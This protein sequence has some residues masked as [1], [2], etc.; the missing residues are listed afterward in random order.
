MMSRRLYMTTLWAWLTLV[1]AFGQ[2]LRVT[3]MPQQPISVALG[4]YSG[5]TWIFGNRYAVVDDKLPGGGIVFFDIPIRSDGKVRESQVQMTVPDATLSASVAGLDNEGVVF[6]HGKLYVSAE[7]DQSIREYDLDGRATGVVFSIPADLGAKA[8]VK[9]GGFEA[10]TW[11][12]ATGQFWTTT[13]LPLKADGKA[14][15]LHRLQRFDERYLANGRWLYRMDEPVLSEKER[16]SVMAYVHGISAMTALDDGRL[17]I[18]EREVYVPAGKPRDILARSFTKTKLYVVNPSGDPA[19]IL[20]KQLLCD[21]ETRLVMTAAGIDVALANYEGMCLGPRLPDGR[22]CLVLIAD[23]Q[24]GMATLATA[25][26]RKQ[27]TREFLK[28]LLLEGEG[29]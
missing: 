21:F 27:L 25:I 29:I 18:L 14:S 8:I 19:E 24:A 20:P 12:A 3:E 23:S 10:F 6:S 26:G 1:S 13:E 5:I 7:S 15:R 28:V 9:N 17:I 2:T 11:N 4:Q 22:R 16:G